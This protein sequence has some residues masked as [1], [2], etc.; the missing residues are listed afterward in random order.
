MALRIKFDL[1][2]LTLD[3]L[4][5]I[6]SGNIKAV[7]VRDIMARFVVDEA[8]VALPEDEAR[9]QV[10]KCSLKELRQVMD[11]LTETVRSLAV[12]PATGGG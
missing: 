8:G 1:D 7:A 6:E 12:P 10:G 11:T 3:D 9:R 5:A 2:L 4:I